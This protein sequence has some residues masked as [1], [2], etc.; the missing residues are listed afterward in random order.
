MMILPTIPVLLIF[1]LCCVLSDFLLF[2]RDRAENGVRS[3][4]TAMHTLSGA[5]FGRLGIGFVIL[6]MGG[7]CA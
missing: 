4:C 2:A 5:I 3:K 1:A 6:T 7:L